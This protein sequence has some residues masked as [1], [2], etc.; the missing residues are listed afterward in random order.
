MISI[1][2][3]GEDALDGGIAEIPD[4]ISLAR[5]GRDRPP[6][7]SGLQLGADNHSSA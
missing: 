4:I 6:P 1:S 2:R 5:N 3:S 7:T